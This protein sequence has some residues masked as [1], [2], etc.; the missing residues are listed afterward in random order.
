MPDVPSVILAWLLP[1]EQEG[2]RGL[3]FFALK[4]GRVPSLLPAPW[5]EV[6]D[7]R[8]L[9]NG[10]AVS[11]GALVG[12]YVGGHEGDLWERRR[13]LVAEAGQGG[14]GRMGAWDPQMRGIQMLVGKGRF[15]Y[16][17]Y[18]HVYFERERAGAG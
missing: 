15:T 4:M 17:I 8:V 10:T 14:G 13:E 12:S 7:V 18:L 1:F 11:E 2:P 6:T 9:V 16:F 5:T 3:G